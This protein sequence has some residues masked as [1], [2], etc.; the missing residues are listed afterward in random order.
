MMACVYQ[1][2]LRTVGIV[3]ALLIAAWLPVAAAQTRVAPANRPSNP[4]RQPTADPL[5]PIEALLEKQK[6]FEAEQKLQPLME[7][8]AKNPQAWFDLGYAQS[9]QGKNREAGASYQKAV[10]LAPDWFEANLNLGVNLADSSNFTAAVPVLRHAVELK[11][12]SGEKPPLS[13]AWAALGRA[14]ERSDPQG[15]IAA[16]DKAVELDPSDPDLLYRKATVMESTGDMD[17]AEK[18]LR[19]A[20]DAGSERGFQGVLVLLINQKRYAEAA[21]WIKKGNPQDPMSLYQLAQLYA[22][23][24]QTPDAIATLQS[25]RGTPAWPEVAPL[26]ASLYTDSR[27]Y[28]KAVSILQEAAQRT[29]SNAE[30]RWSLGSA[31]VHEHK[32]PEAEN[33]MTEAL[34][35]N[36]RLQSDPWELAYAAQQNKH[37]ELAIR[38]LDFRAQRLKETATTY[39]I[40]AVCYDGLGAVKPAAANYKLFLDADAGKLPDEEFKARH[41]LKALE[42]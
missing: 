29:P 5:Q 6:F 35:I 39:W 42:H 14:L 12:S 33:E 10:D 9:H 24:G 4:S 25:L 23:A 41:R 32:Y 8:Q 11:P 1:R 16:Y 22:Q 3:Q 34:K 31:L 17:G 13:H 30:V 37:Y 2:M 36:P 21:A 27:Q 18:L 38:V 40:R 19:K 15:A 7:T 28:D 26:L 20:A